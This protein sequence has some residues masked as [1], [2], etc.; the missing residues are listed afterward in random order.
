M[1]YQERF[2]LR[3]RDAGNETW[4]LEAANELVNDFVR[5]VRD[6]DV[7]SDL[8][9]EI[10][11][12]V[13]KPVLVEAFKR[14]ISAEKRT[15]IRALLL[16]AG[17]TLSQYHADLGERIKVRPIGPHGRGNSVDQKLV[18]KFNRALLSTAAER[19][20]LTKIFQDALRCAVH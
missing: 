16:K 2:N 11:L 18:Q 10:E 1:F 12:P 17:L 9:D 8:I 5:F 3:H 20:R 14:V 7:G 13:P 4:T 19:T 15:V 6:A